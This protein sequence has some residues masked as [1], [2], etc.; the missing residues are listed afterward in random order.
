VVFGPLKNNW[1]KERDQWEWETGQK[2][3]KTDFLTVYGQAHLW[4]L[5]LEIICAMFQKT[6]V[7]PFN[8]DVITDTMM[9]PSKET[10]CKG[11]LP[12]KP[13]SPI[14]LVAK[15]LQ[16]LSLQDLD[17]DNIDM[18]IP[19]PTN[20]EDVNMEE[21]NLSSGSGPVSSTD[22]TLAPIY[23]A[24]LLPAITETL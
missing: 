1:T 9:A 10:L 12:V 22:S 14:K 15:L 24:E 19:N 5:T 13:S 6:G 3:D 20:N 23:P 7:W 11:F 18:D 2:I 4:T 16:N 21:P 17:N 8:P